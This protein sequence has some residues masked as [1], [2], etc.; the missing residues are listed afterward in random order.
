MS[1]CSFW[2][3]SKH[4]HAHPQIPTNVTTDQAGSLPLGLN[5][6]VFGLYDYEDGGIGNCG[7]APPW[8]EGG[9]DK[10][11]GQ[12]I[13]ILGGASSVGQHVIQLAKLSGFSPIVT[14]A[15]LRNADRLRQ[16]GATHIL[17]RGLAFDALA[18]E[19]ERIVLE[20]L[21]VIY[22][23]V[24]SLDTQNFAYDILAPGGA[25][26]VVRPVAVSEA[27][28]VPEKRVSIVY[29]NAFRPENQRLAK[30]LFSRLHHL[31][32]EGAIK[33]RV[34]STVLLDAS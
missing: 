1:T 25:L 33:G 4:L 2:Q 12:P 14:T 20:P 11:A 26:A 3:E 18:S 17:D 6:A 34:V 10:Y 29:A 32:E 19:L 31:L 9:R 16:L 28:R 7:L 27:K 30:S 24:A 23:A 5:T 8:E 22:D 13:L 21:T 15:S